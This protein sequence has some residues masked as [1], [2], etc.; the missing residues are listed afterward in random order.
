MRRVVC[1]ALPEIRLEVAAARCSAKASKREEFSHRPIAVVI[2][3]HG[4]VV[5]TE[6]DVR[7][8]TRIDVVSPQAS[9]RGVQARQTMAAA[10]A[11][12]A[13]LR[14][15]VVAEEAVHTALARVA[16]VALA[17]GPVTSFDAAQDVVWIDV[18]G[19]AH[20][21]GGEGELASSIRAR[22]RDLGHACRVAVA[23]GPRISAA[24]AR[25]ASTRNKSQQ[26]ILVV[27]PGKDVDAMRALPIAALALGNDVSS[28][29]RNLG[30]LVCGDLQRLPRPGLGTRLGSRTHDVMQLL[31]GIDDAPLDA[32]RPPD[33]PEER[34]DLDWGAT[35]IE[36]LSFVAKT[37]C[38]RLAARL[39]GRKM[40]AGRLE[41]CLTLDRA[42]L[43][44]SRSFVSTFAIP[45]PIPIARAADLLAVVRARLE[46]VSLPAPVLAAALRASQLTCIP[47]RNLDLLSPES[48][49]DRALPRL[50]AE[51]GAELGLSLVGT[52]ALVDTWVPHKRT[53]LLP[54][55]RER[56][57]L[58]IS[59][60]ARTRR[61]QAHSLRKLVTSAL[62]PSRLVAP[63][64]VDPQT[65]A[66][67]LPVIRIEAIEWWRFAKYRAGEGVYDLAI[68]WVD[69]KRGG[70]LAWIELHDG[71][72]LLR[73][74]I[75]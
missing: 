42:L 49:T 51:L 75:D 26:S 2:A 32:W 17:F 35:S 52:L 20:L 62:E 44:D 57:S 45:L 11:K 46:H 1:I 41:L 36:S 69:S 6:R 55:N 59:G 68:A 48:K 56:F 37:L 7:G 33:V 70:A 67:I 5:K 60:S 63:S 9:Q 3:R 25:Y 21:H 24:I 22:V 73:G 16:E 14:V 34:L 15:C 30:L 58:S 39:E 27:P 10:R 4:G 74:W 50:V 12:C 54:F 8:N 71:N 19:C 23:G 38:D 66:E 13:E 40:S 31:E 72:A 28:W 65:L 29:L 18:S 43:S 64:C 53:R 61:V 47:A